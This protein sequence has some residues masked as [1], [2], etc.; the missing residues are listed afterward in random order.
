MTSAER[1]ELSKLVRMSAA[2]AKADAEAHG[3]AVLA[4]AEAKLAAEYK[5]EDEAWAD[6]VET[7]EKQIADADATIAAV[8]RERGIPENF[9]PG[10]H[11][12]WY[13]RGE[14]AFKERRG[15]I[16]RVVQAEVAARVTEAKVEIDRQAVQLATR[17][18][19]AGLTS[20]EAQKFIAEMPTPAQLFRPL[21]RLKLHDGQLINLPGTVTEMDRV[22]PHETDSR[23]KCEYCGEAFTPSRKDS[24]YCQAACRVADY[25]KR[26]VSSEALD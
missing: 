25:R 26:Q 17:I 23:Y 7:A 3:K 24:K 6:I 4:D 10:I 2:V 14:N 9:R 5:R 13:S 19:Q 21:E 1:T 11:L 20:E 18:T 15:E 22:T 16:R 12:G 8:C